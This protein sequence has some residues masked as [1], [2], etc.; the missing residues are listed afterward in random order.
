MHGESVACTEVGDF[1]TR[2][3]IEEHWKAVR[4]LGVGPSCE[5]LVGGEL[6]REG[7][8]PCAQDLA[9]LALCFAGHGVGLGIWAVRVGD[10]LGWVLDQVAVGCRCLVPRFGHAPGVEVGKVRWAQNHRTRDWGGDCG[11]L[12]AEPGLKRHLLGWQSAVSL[13][14]SQ[15]CV[16]AA[17]IG[18]AVG[19]CSG[20]CSAGVPHTDHHGSGDAVDNDLTPYNPRHRAPPPGQFGAGV[21]ACRST[22]EQIGSDHWPSGTGHFS[23]RTRDVHDELGRF[24]DLEIALRGASE[25]SDALSADVGFCG[26]SAAVLPMHVLL[27]E[28][29][30]V[31]AGELHG[32]TQ[33]GSDGVSVAESERSAGQGSNVGAEHASDARTGDPESPVW[34]WPS[35]TLPRRMCVTDVETAERG[36]REVQET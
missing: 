33:R 15:I 29:G 1:A 22:G 23:R 20:R 12:I 7:E 27:V 26:S 32:V 17:L 30:T 34:P 10:S 36:D 21:N 6:R 18:G 24:D 16:D 4:L 25:Q 28:G 9:E 3:E 5:L 2:V 14:R 19:R 35:E 13:G 11:P 31:G 8:S